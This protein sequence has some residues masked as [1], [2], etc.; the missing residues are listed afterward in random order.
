[1]TASAL[2]VEQAGR[3]GWSSAGASASVARAA[4][5]AGGVRSWTQALAGL[6]EARAAALREVG[7]R[8]Q[9]VEAGL[10]WQG[11]A[12]ALFLDALAEHVAPVPS[13][14]PLLEQAAGQVRLAGESLAAQLEAVAAAIGAAAALL[15]AGLRGL[16]LLEG[17]VDDL[18][19]LGREAGLPALQ[20]SLDEARGHPL[21]GQVTGFLEQVGWA[22]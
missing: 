2:L 1:M 10:V 15:D 22:C 20:A 3:L 16:G 4:S 11:P 5:L 17:A 14:P 12:A 13:Y 9:S 19:S 6:L 18:V 21:L 7:H 8:H